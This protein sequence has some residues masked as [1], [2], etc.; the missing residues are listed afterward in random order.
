MG[1]GIGISKGVGRLSRVIWY[2]VAMAIGGVGILEKHA[3]WQL[4][5][6]LPPTKKNSYFLTPKT[7]YYGKNAYFRPDLY[8]YG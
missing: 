2:M 3:S 7:H 5:N 4:V 1:R 6:R 8:A